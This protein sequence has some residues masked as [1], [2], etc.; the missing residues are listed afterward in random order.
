MDSKN[1]KTDDKYFATPEV[2]SDFNLFPWSL[3]IGEYQDM[4]TGYVQNYI[5]K[6]NAKRIPIKA[7]PFGSQQ[8]P[9]DG[10]RTNIRSQRG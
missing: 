2:L 10:K 6:K 5:E 7:S 3:T 4:V 1:L 8:D 9:K